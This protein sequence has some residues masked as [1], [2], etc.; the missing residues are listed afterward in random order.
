M[1]IP[2]WRKPTPYWR[3]AIFFSEVRI[4]NEINIIGIDLAIVYSPGMRFDPPV[5][6]LLLN[7][8]SPWPVLR[9]NNSSHL[10]NE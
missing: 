9:R 6:I 1:D 2:S 5:S 7:E 3:G 8:M 4:I 10:L